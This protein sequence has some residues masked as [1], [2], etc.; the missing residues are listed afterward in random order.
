[1]LDAREAKFHNRRLTTKARIFWSSVISSSAAWE[2][3]YLQFLTRFVC[4]SADNVLDN[5]HLL[6]RIHKAQKNWNLAHQCST[7]KKSPP[8]LKS[9]SL[10]SGTW[11]HRTRLS[12]KTS[13]I[14]V[15]VNDLIIKYPTI[16]SKS[17]PSEKIDPNCFVEIHVNCFFCVSTVRVVHQ[18]DAFTEFIELEN[19]YTACGF[20]KNRK[21]FCRF[22][23]TEN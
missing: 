9:H 6:I 11:S 4:Y 12:T 14:I 8:L 2:V 7:K 23:Q 3:C 10:A 22:G 19:K 13:L 17:S 21:L 5:A 16:N 18:Q 15:N 1:M 20:W